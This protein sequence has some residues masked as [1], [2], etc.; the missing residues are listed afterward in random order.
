MEDQFI[1]N[2][3]EEVRSIVRSVVLEEINN[4]GLKA[5]IKEEILGAGMTREVITRMVTETVDS[6]FRS[7]MNA[8]NGDVDAK[9]WA[10]MDRKITYLVDSKVDKILGSPFYNY[11]LDVQEKLQ[12]ATAKELDRL[13]KEKYMISLEIKPK[14][15]GTLPVEDLP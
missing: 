13:L 3:K 4:L 10:E 8:P 2:I 1:L 6:H 15:K 14:P 7:A 9:I 11:R 12:E 5:V